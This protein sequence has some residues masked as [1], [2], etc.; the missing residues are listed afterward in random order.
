MNHTLINFNIPN[1][2][3]ANFDQLV[4][5]KRVSRTSILNTMIEEFCRNEIKLIE[6]DGNLNELITSIERKNK[7]KKGQPIPNTL[8]KRSS[9]VSSSWEESYNEPKT[10]RSSD[11]IYSPFD[12]GFSL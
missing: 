8:S 7:I 1:H 2:L 4:G 6:S 9:K 11:D 10:V 5:F 12:D 3:K